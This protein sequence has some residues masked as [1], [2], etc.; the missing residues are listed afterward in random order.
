MVRSAQGRVSNHEAQTFDQG[1]STTLKR[2]LP[3]SMR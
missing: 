2:A 3:L 1:T